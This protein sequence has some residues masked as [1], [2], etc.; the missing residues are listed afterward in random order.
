MLLLTAIA[1]AD[2]AYS[3]VKEALQVCASYN[4]AVLPEGLVG[5]KTGLQLS[6]CRTWRRVHRCRKV[7][8]Q[9]AGMKSRSPGRRMVTC[10]RTF[11]SSGQASRSGVS[12]SGIA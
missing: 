10:P 2:A 9:K 6:I 3:T 1:D 5:I 11:C 12:R 4:N 8:H 7:P